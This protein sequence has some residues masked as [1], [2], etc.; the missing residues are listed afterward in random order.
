M[1]LCYK[2]KFG[3]L[4]NATNNIQHTPN[5]INGFARGGHSCKHT[6]HGALLL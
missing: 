5:Y 6:L 4:V 2:V 3:T 1:F